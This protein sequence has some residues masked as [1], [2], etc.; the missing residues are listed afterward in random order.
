MGTRASVGVKACEDERA[1]N[2][3]VRVL[4]LCT[5]V[6]LLYEERPAFHFAWSPTSFLPGPGVDE[7]KEEP[8]ELLY[9]REFSVENRITR[10]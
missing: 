6:L 2:K 8:W 3:D 5:R 10:Y 1:R 7:G 4:V 9:W